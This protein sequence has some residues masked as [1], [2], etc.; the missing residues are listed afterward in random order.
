GLYRA[1]I[2]ALGLTLGGFLAGNGFARARA[3][4]RYVTVKGV[5][6]H[7]VKADL[8]IWPL[9]VVGADNDLTAANAKVARSIAG[10]R[11]FLTQRGIDTTQIQ[12][13]DFSVTDA[14]ANQYA[15]DR[16]PANRYIVQQM[17]LV[18]STRPEVVRINSRAT[19]TAR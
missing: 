4:D 1:A 19:R 5:A 10:V 8:A 11:Q 6:E 15:S 9:R 12:L 2:L 3:S 17:V 7:E 16:R 18:R 14:L 13:A